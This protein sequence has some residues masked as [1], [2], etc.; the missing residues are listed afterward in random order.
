MT[1]PRNPDK[2]HLRILGTRGV[3]AQHGGF[4][5]FAEHLAPYMVQ[6]GWRVTVYC[7]EDGTGP[8]REDE[9]QGVRRVIIPVNQ[10]GAKG[11]VLFDWKAMRHAIKEKGVVLTLGYNTAIFSIPYRLKRIPHLM[12]MDGI[13]WKRA[14]W[15]PME[16]LWL[17]L[18]EWAGCYL[19]NHLIA[20]HPEIENHLA[21]RVSRK[22]ITMI[23]YGSDALYENPPPPYEDLPIEPGK[24]ALVIA[25]PEPENSILEIV[26]AFSQQERGYKL[27]VLGNYDEQNPYHRAV[28]DAAN[29]AVLFPGAI[30][31]KRNV[32]AL[33]YHAA[34]YIHG[35][36]VGGTNPSLVEALGAGNPIIAHDNNFNSW[37]AGPVSIYFA[38][39]DSLSNALT[40][41]TPDSE[42]LLTMKKASIQLHRRS[43]AWSYVLDKYHVTLPA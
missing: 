13:E 35:H 25:R 34:F 16:R 14:K 39:A 3:P 23:P 22:K 29:N 42:D 2:P 41:L 40:A 21:T 8:I 10:P 6:Q 15:S 7:Q 24:Y 28:I 36:Q 38:D 12:N 32:Q 1:D 5:T 17:Y 26:S 11:T 4:E 30:Y 19:A 27:V 20:D 43:F 33:R 37:V 9:W 31:D 18:N